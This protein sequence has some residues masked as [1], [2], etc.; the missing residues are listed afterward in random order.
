MNPEAS[1]PSPVLFCVGCGNQDQTLLEVV[2]RDVIRRPGRVLVLCAVCG[3]TSA[4]NPSDVKRAAGEVRQE[5]L[6][7]GEIVKEVLE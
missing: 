6:H 5:T 7:K 1:K 3:R 2:A 4:C